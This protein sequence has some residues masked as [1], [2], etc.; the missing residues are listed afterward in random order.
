MPCAAC[1]DVAVEGGRN[2]K[3]RPPGL[4]RNG[5][6]PGS[7]Y[8]EVLTRYCWRKTMLRPV[9]NAVITT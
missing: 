6:T 4:V 5:A 2:R 3:R 7:H 1:R 9:V 8:C